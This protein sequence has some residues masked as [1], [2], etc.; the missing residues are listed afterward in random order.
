MAELTS[1]VFIDCNGYKPLPSGETLRLIS[2]ER[3]VQSV[4][5]LSSAL[6]VLDNNP[7]IKILVANIPNVE[8]FSKFRALHPDGISILVTAM[9]MKEYSAE[10]GGN[11]ECLVDH[12]IA[13]KGRE[14][15]TTHE[16][17]ITLNKIYSDQIFGIDKYLAPNTIIHREVVKS[18]AEREVLNSR[19]L[20]FAEACHLGQHTSRMAFGITEELLMNTIYDAPA[21]AG[22]PRFQNVD[23]TTVVELE[24]QEYGELTYGCDGQILAISCSDPFGALRKDKVFQY[25]KK[26]L[27]RNASEGLIDTKRGGAGLGLFK[28]LYSSHGLVCNVGDGHKTEIMALI[29][30]NDQLRDFS[31]MARSIHFFSTDQSLASTNLSA[32]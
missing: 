1:I 5:D 25:L 26:V 32:K 28:I 17:R 3:H 12:I 24:P 22:I 16:L 4:T 15:W 9:P 2:G 19:V 30:I 29:D 11:E 21:A 23:Q 27:K 8:L 13:N 31:S 14:G 20:A 18:S 10:L 6:A 7:N